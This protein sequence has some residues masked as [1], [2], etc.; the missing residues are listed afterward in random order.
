MQSKQNQIILLGRWGRL[1]FH[2]RNRFIH[3]FGNALDNSIESV[4]QLPIEERVITLTSKKKGNA[5][6]LVIRN[7]TKNKSEDIKLNESTLKS[8]KDEPFHGYGMKSMES[9]C[10]NI[11]ETCLST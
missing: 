6:S 11:T 2:I 9:I 4:I 3:V 7:Y 5:I 10:E 1:E 8:T